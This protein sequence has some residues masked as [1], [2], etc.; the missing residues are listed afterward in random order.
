[1]KNINILKRFG[2][3]ILILS[4]TLQFVTVGAQTSIDITYDAEN[5]SITV[6]LNTDKLSKTAVLTVEKDG[7]FYVLAEFERTSKDAFEYSCDLP[8][9]CSSG[10]YTA[11]VTIGGE[12]DTED[13]DHINKGLASEAMISVN[14][15]TPDNFAGILQSVGNAIAVDYEEFLIYRNPLTDIYFFYKPLGDMTSAEFAVIYGKALAISKISNAGDY[16]KAIEMLASNA[17][18]IGFDYDRFTK[19]E[20]AEKEEIIGRFQ[21]WKNEQTS[22]KTQY[23]HWFALADINNNRDNSIA[24][25][26]KAIFETYDDIIGLNLNEYNKSA[27]KDEVIRKMM[28]DSYDTIKD[29]CDA[30][31]DAVDK[32]GTVSDGGGGGSGGRPSKGSGGGGGSAMV[33]WG[34]EIIPTKPDETSVTNPFA[35]VSDTHWCNKPI[36]VLFEK[37]I[38]NGV[39]N[40]HFAPESKVTR[41]EFAKMVVYALF[42][43][44]KTSYG[45]GFDDVSQSD[46][47]Y[48]SVHTAAGI[49]IINGNGNGMFCP[50]DKVSRQDAAVIICRALEKKGVVMNNGG[51]AF[52]DNEKIADYARNAASMLKNAGV[53]NGMSD[54]SFAPL[55]VLTR[56]QAAKLLYE[57]LN[58][59]S[60]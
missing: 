2:M 4:L 15:A 58:I 43:D 14:S 48:D 51:S 9:Y 24:T 47:Y 27:D 5:E 21:N 19:L 6:N 3:L 55:D 42:K 17:A 37:G 39:D 52:S 32:V 16:E 59:I 35:D 12:T 26:R 41:A 18:R 29:L 45:A 10:R 28:S 36:S 7:I 25:Y 8:D 11:K 13:F 33:N 1:M 40:S 38:I 22:L 56:A 49:G 46:W 54:G 53:L 44:S 23:D 50:E 20:D 30:F 31:E 57:A 34:S 60:Q